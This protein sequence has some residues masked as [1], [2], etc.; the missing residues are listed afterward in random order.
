[1][2]TV[3]SRY[4]YGPNGEE[5]AVITYQSQQETASN[6]FSS[7]AVVAATTTPAPQTT[8]VT[9]CHLHHTAM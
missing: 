8:A 2:L 7:P 1:M 3:H 4:C 6:T 5:T 9:D